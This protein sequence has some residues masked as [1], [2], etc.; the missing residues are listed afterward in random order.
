MN[1]DDTVC[2]CYH[3][4]L[5][6][7]LRFA[8]RERPSRPSQMT[9]CLSAGTGCGWCIP[10][11]TKIAEKPDLQSVDHIVVHEYADA[12]QQYLQDDDSRHEF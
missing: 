9:Q 8:Q 1:L 5:R 7:L 11:L 6:K 3:V 2:Y 4:P 10:L 12:R